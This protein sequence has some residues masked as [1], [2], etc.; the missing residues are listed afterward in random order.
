MPTVVRQLNE[1]L[2]FKKVYLEK[3]FANGKTITIRWGLVKPTRH[4]VFI[5]CRGLIYARA[6]I[7]GFKHLRFRELRSESLASMD[8]FSSYHEMLRDLRRI[9]PFVKEDDWVTVIE[10]EVL[11]RLEKPVSKEW[12]TKTAAT[13]S[14]E[15]LARGVYRDPRER[16]A[17]A[18]VAAGRGILEALEVSGVSLA[19]FIEILASLRL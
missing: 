1:S 8:G 17:L 13:A 14:R 19:R 12:L 16:V 6:R 4:H 9:Y 11:E 2:S 15:A 5:E 10:F 18:N 3:V 7:K